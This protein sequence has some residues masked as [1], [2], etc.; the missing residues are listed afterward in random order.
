MAVFTRQLVP[1]RPRTLTAGRDV[2]VL[3]EEERL[4]TA[5]LDQARNRPRPEGVMRGEVTDSEL[6]RA[7]LVVDGEPKLFR[8]RTRLRRFFYRLVL[9]GH[10]VR[11]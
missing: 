4:V 3:G 6:D 1:A 2:C 11:L 7:S 10:S 9:F 8:V 5:L